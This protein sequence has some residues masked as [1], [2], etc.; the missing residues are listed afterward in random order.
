MRSMIFFKRFSSDWRSKYYLLLLLC[1]R[2]TTMSALHHTHTHPYP[3]HISPPPLPR[4]PSSKRRRLLTFSS[5]SDEE[6]YDD[7]PY[8]GAHR[9]SRPLT[10]NAPSQLERW[11][12]WR[13]ERKEEHRDSGAEDLDAERRRGRGRR[14]SFVDR[15]SDNDDEEERLFRL[16][17]AATFSGRRSVSRERE[18]HECMSVSPALRRC[19]AESEDERVRPKYWSGELFRGRERCVSEDFEARE[20]RRERERR[21]R[22]RGWLGDDDDEVETEAARWVRWRRVKRTKTE[23][24]RPL[25]GWR[26]A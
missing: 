26:R 2:Q 19:D 21:H 20:R 17:V 13:D 5:S 8:S 4:R 7:Y 23:E 9:P 12:I 6:N 24:W 22:E 25:A 15:V 3:R 10:R 1:P 11:N 14:V 18:R 16:R